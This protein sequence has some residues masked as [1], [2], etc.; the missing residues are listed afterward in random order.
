VT[1]W[2]KVANVPTPLSFNALA[3]GEPFPISGRIFLVRKLESWAIRRCRFRDPS[4]RRFHLVPGC[5]G[6]TDGQTYR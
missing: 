1:Y 5:N 3:R 2:L 6:Q 4:L